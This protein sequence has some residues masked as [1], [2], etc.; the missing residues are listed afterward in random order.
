MGPCLRQI[1]AEAA[2]AAST[3][4]PRKLSSNLTSWTRAAA[5]HT[6]PL[7]FVARFPKN[8]ARPLAATYLAATFARTCV[9]GTAARLQPGTKN[10]ARELSPIRPK[11]RNR[12][13]KKVL[14]FPR[15]RTR[16]TRRRNRSS[17]LGSNGSPPWTKL[18]A[19]A[20]SAAA[21]LSARSGAASFA[22]PAL[23]WATQ[24]RIAEHVPITESP[25]YCNASPVRKTRLLRNLPFGRSPA[26]KSNERRKRF[27]YNLLWCFGERRLTL[28]HHGAV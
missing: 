18:C 17:Y 1:C 21:P 8:Y 22:M 6:Y 25:N 10:S 7:S 19:A 13:S 4:A 14:G 5:Y 15:R 28:I 26:S 3:R 9:P 12:R 2:A 11:L 16:V 27:G 24:R 20:S 23:L